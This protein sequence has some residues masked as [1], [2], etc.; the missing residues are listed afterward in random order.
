[1]KMKLETREHKN[2]AGKKMIILFINNWNVWEIPS[3]EWTPT[4]QTAVA[5][6]YAL[7]AKNMRN[8]IIENIE[9]PSAFEA[10]WVKENI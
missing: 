3:K 1:M 4:V 9:T 2:S 8:E 5:R 10:V 7:G 6:A